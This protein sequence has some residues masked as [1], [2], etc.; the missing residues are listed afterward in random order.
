MKR[1]FLVAASAAFFFTVS[2]SADAGKTLQDDEKVAE[3]ILRSRV[4]GGVSPQGKIVIFPCNN[5]PTL[6]CATITAEGRMVFLFVAKR[7]NHEPQ[8]YTKLPS[9][10]EAVFFLNVF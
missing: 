4:C 3:D 6:M 8:R 2:V 9:Y 5:P 10:T 7:T 1:W